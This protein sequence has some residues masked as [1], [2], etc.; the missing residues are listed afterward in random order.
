MRIAKVVAGVVLTLALSG[1]LGNFAQ[2]RSDLAVSIGADGQ[3]VTSGGI[4]IEPV[5]DGKY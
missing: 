2:V 4:T 3:L 1:C 5:F